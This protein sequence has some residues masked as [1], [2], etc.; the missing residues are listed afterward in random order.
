MDNIQNN[1]EKK[2]EDI[3]IYGLFTVEEFKPYA[4]FV[5]IHL[6]INIISDIIYK[7]KR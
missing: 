4:Y 2:I 7:V 3:N 6:L 5:L 1:Y